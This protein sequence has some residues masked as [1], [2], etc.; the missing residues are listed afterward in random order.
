MKDSSLGVRVDEDCSGRGDVFV[1][2][3]KLN[4]RIVK[5]LVNPVDDLGLGLSAVK[6]NLDVSVGYLFACTLYSVHW[7]RVRI[8]ETG[9]QL[10]I[11]GLVYLGGKLFKS[12]AVVN[13]CCSPHLPEESVVL[14]ETGELF[15]FDLDS[16]LKDHS[17]S[18]KFK[19]TRLRVSWDN[20]ANTG[21]NKWLGCE[22]SWH[23]RILIVARSDAVFLVD[24]RF[25]ECNVECLARIEMLGTTGLLEKDQFV[26]FSKAGSDGF[27]FT[28]ASNRLLLLCDVR[29]PMLPVLQWHHGLDNPC[30]ID[31]FRLSEL[32]SHSRDSNYKWASDSGFCIIMGSFWN[33]EFNLFC[34]GPSLPASRGSSKISKVC[35][36]F[37]A[38]GLPSDFSLSV[39]QCR[40][41]TCLVKEEFIKDALPEWIDWRQKKDLVLGFGILDKNLSS[42]LFEPDEFGGFSL[43]RLMSSGKLE[44][45]RYCALWDFGKGFK[46]PHNE[47]LLHFESNLTHPVG[48]EEYKFPK[49]FK[50]LKLD[51]LQKFLNGNLASVLVSCLKNQS[52]SPQEK[53]PFNADFY[54]ILCEM[55]K[56]C[57]VLQSRSAPAVSDVLKDISLPSS[58]HEV[59][60]RRMWAGLPVD[61]LHLAFTNYS[62][63]LEVIVD[64]TMSLEFLVVSDQLQ[65][66]PFFFR[67]PSS[68]STKWSH[69]V[70]RGNDLVGP[71]LPIPI[72][73]TLGEV[74]KNRGLHVGEA[75]EYST[76]LS[77]HCNEVIEVASEVQDGH[78]ASLDDLIDGAWDASQK[79]KP[80]FLYKQVANLNKCSKERTTED[81]FIYESDYND[82]RFATFISK[83]PENDS[84][85]R[86]ETA[87]P[88]IFDD[89]CPVEL[90]FDAQA[91]N[92]GEVELK[93]YKLLKRQFSNWQ[94]GFSSYQ[95]FCTK[96]QY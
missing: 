15:L 27:Y 38:W 71:V 42:Q 63:I 28:V 39:H 49:K 53:E 16:C 50:Y 43:I 41:G 88:E 70:Q 7:F 69:K 93:T 31:V 62:E 9:Q 6:G 3:Y 29:K 79:R 4:Q 60:L 23:P 77:F 94:K 19:G 36:P 87:G 2:K 59:A 56:A 57:G 65:L 18:R 1:A 83:V 25:E 61:I 24:L 85:G 67:K 54:K 68:R 84:S 58:I 5:I 20:S 90:K 8:R 12:A 92:F 72:L 76:E 13:A 22:F 32:R 17:L 44:S 86:M 91:I 30:Y 14:L 78:V 96:F 89:L 10:G 40:C 45:Q 73:F 21:N 51:Y 37:Y 33:C 64:R 82:E 74:H 95:D 52:T 26:A 46:E 81:S 55:L 75:N 48:E 80:F 47:P 34:Y 11:P 35:K 66:P